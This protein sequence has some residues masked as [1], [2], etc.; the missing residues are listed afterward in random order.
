MHTATSQLSRVDNVVHRRPGRPRKA[1]ITLAELADVRKGLSGAFMSKPERARI[2]K[3]SLALHGDLLGLKSGA[4]AARPKYGVGDVTPERMANARQ[5]GLR[6]SREAETN[7][8][9]EEIPLQRKR[10]VGRLEQLKSRGTI[11]TDGFAA[12]LR[13]Q[14]HVASSYAKAGARICSYAPRMVDCPGHPDL[15]P[16]EKAMQH[17]RA[18]AMAYRAVPVELHIVL[19]WMAE[20]AIADQDHRVVASI[21]WPALAPDARIQRFFGLIELTCALL[22]RHFGLAEGHKWAKLQ[23]SRVAEEL[24]A[25]IKLAGENKFVVS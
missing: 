23:I 17:Q 10:L 12:A 14:S 8:R 25:N 9:G 15:S 19:D 13:F 11:S 6:L 2:A 22:A 1:P 7:D 18:I 24:Y 3:V 21:Y 20:N 5:N 4:Y 16:I